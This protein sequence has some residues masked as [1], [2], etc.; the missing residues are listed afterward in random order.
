MYGS[1]SPQAGAAPI[2]IKP[3]IVDVIQELAAYAKSQ[4]MS[5]A[6]EVLAELLCALYR[7][8]TPAR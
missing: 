2:R 1:V 5:A 3:E 8:P 6:D 7:Q 4:Q